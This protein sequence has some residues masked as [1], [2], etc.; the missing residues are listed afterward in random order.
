[1]FVLFGL[2]QFWVTSY[3]PCLKTDHPLDNLFSHFFL[4]FCPENFSE[5]SLPDGRGLKFSIS[6]IQS[7]NVTLELNV[8]RNLIPTLFQVVRRKMNPSPLESEDMDSGILI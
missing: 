1:M 2:D 3:N 7:T 4:F 6:I 5:K 8:K